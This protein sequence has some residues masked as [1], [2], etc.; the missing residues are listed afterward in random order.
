MVKLI[1]FQVFNSHVW[2]VTTILDIT[3]YRNVVIAESSIDS[4]ALKIVFTKPHISLY[5]HIF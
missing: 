4:V 5:Y 3:Y 1:L 2:P